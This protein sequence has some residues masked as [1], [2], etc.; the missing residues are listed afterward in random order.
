M[1]HKSQLLSKLGFGVTV[2]QYPFL[3]VARLSAHG[4]IVC[5]FQI[6]IFKNNG[7]PMAIRISV[8]Y[9]FLKLVVGL[10]LTGT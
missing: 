1:T 7:A 3:F 9:V 10:V 6:F 5:V 4:V 8:Q 2:G